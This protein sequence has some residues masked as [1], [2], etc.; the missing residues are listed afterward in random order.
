MASLCVLNHKGVTHVF[1]RTDDLPSEEMFYDRCWFIVLNKGMK[2]AEAYADL[3]LASKY[4][5]ASYNV[6]LTG[7]LKAFR[8]P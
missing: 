4:Y 6:D 7:N 3:F 1:E 2:D 5:G 8:W